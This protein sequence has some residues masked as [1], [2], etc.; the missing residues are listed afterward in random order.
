MLPSPVLSVN[1]PGGLV[2]SSLKTRWPKCSSIRFSEGRNLSVTSFS[3]AK[4]RKRRDPVSLHI[5]A[6]AVSKNSV[7]SSLASFLVIEFIPPT[8]ICS[9]NLAMC[10]ADKVWLSFLGC[11]RT[12][13]IAPMYLLVGEASVGAVRLCRFC[14]FC[15]NLSKLSSSW[16][17]SYCPA[18]EQNNSQDDLRIRKNCA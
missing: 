6:C 17:R 14:L 9:A 5:S 10:S 4:A 1:V 11:F 16:S 18:T 13:C 3:S 8:S 12:T 7:S 2:E 15:M